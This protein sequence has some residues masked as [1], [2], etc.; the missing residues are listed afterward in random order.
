MF[1]FLKRIDL[2]E[3]ANRLCLGQPCERVP[4]NAHPTVAS[5]TEAEALAA[6]IVAAKL[7]RGYEPVLPKP[8]AF[9]S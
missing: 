7:K 8:A 6:K 9:A 4:A 5:P 3:H 1:I 2:K